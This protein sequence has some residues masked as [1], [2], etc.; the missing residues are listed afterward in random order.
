MAMASKEMCS[1]Y[2]EKFLT[3]HICLEAYKDPRVLPCYHTFCLGCI[4]DHAAK[5]G[6]QDKFFCPVCR[7]E[8][9][10]PP[11]DFSVNPAIIREQLC[12]VLDEAQYCNKHD[13]EFLTFYCEEDDTVA[14]RDC[15][16]ETHSKHNFKKLEEVAKV[17]RHLIQEKLKC[18]PSE[19]LSRFENAQTAI[20]RTEERLIEN[21]AKVFGLVDSQKVTMIKEIKENSKAF[22]MGIK[23]YYQRVE[24]DVRQQTNA[25]LTS[26][27]QRLETYRTEKQ[28]NYTGIERH[29]DDKRNEILAEVK[30]L[31]TT[32]MKALEAEKDK[33]EMNKISIQSIRDFAQQL[34]DVGSDIEVMTHSKKLQTRIQEL[35]TVEP[36]FDIKFTDITFTPG[37]TKMEVGLLCPEIPEP[38]PLSIKTRS[39]TAKTY[40]DP[41]ACFGSLAQAI[42][43]P[44]ELRQFQKPTW[45]EKP[46]PTIR[47]YIEAKILDI[48]WTG[49][50]CFLVVF[51]TLIGYMAWGF[52]GNTSPETVYVFSSTGQCN[53]KISI[54]AWCITTA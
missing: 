1:A 21:Q 46:L 31:T 34:M 36:V 5:N 23:V 51:A 17:Q 25:Y 14:C 39:I 53:R 19:K 35:K 29:I 48:R 3:C 47:F 2:S 22:D 50:G 54:G 32:Q 43:F 10:V 9:P 7:Q 28:S 16:L 18:L 52:F 42:E 44:N 15:I 38:R 12:H 40:R 6:V 24:K 26:V 13:G 27:K 30:A 11:V 33:Q 37:Q 8:A 45:L 20:G 4:A 49:G 41:F